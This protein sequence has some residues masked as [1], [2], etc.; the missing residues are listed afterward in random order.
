VAALMFAIPGILALIGLIYVRPQEFSAALRGM[1]FLYL[2]LGLA[3]FG[4]AVDLRLHLLRPRLLPQ[5]KWIL[6]FVAWCLMTVLVRAPDTIEPVFLQVGVSAVLALTIGHGV[7]TLRGFQTV[8]G[9]ILVSSLV[10]SAIG[11]HQAFAP[12]Q[13]LII[14][15]SRPAEAAAMRP[16]GRSCETARE[17]LADEDAAEPG[18]DY[19]CERVGLLGTTTIGGRVRYIGV[20]EDPNFLALTVG[21]ALPFAFAFAE[22]KRSLVRLLLLGLSIVLVLGCI[23][24]SESRGGQLV[25]LA[26]MGAYFVK[27]FGTRGLLLGLLVAVPLLLWG[28]RSGEEAESSSLE[29]LECW[30]EG[31]SMWRAYPIIGVGTSQF[32][33]HHYLTAHNSYVLAA[34]ELGSFGFFL[35]SIVLYGAVR[36]PIDALRR[37]AAVPEAAALRTWAMALL[38]SMVGLLVGIFFL[39]FCYHY[40]LWIYIG[41]AGALYSAIRTHDPEWRIRFGWR[42]LMAVVAIDLSLLALLYVYTRLKAP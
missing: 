33:E 7:Q 11:A 1:P 17:C 3:A 36:V 16:D 29:R 8:A 31:M 42:D 15:E 35:W 9:M 25:F 37:F 27:R 20:L 26:V 32:V 22:R 14:D 2:A 6:L 30:Y 40:V 21:I 23:I 39:S 24:F 12:R 5:V 38:A 28:G 34:A 19:R 4:I 41:L 13:C 10:L 18:A